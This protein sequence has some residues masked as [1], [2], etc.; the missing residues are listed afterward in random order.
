MRER[1][2]ETNN[3]QRCHSNLEPPHG[4]RVVP[5]ARFDVLRPRPDPV[6]FREKV[7][8]D[9]LLDALHVFLLVEHFRLAPLQ[10]PQQRRRRRPLEGLHL[11]LLGRGG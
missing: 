11:P 9:D 7:A 8:L 1:E 3:D 6:E 5:L 4:G 2:R 10:V